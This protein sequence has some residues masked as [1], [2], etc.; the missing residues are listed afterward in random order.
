V[1]LE[2]RL[3]L[4]RYLHH[5]L[6]AEGLESLKQAL[7]EVEEGPS[8]GG[9]SHFFHA[10]A[11]RRGIRIPVE[12]LREYDTR[13]LG[14]E[15]RLGRARG[16]L[17]LRYFQYLALLY[18]EVLLD[19]LT[20]DS[21]ALAA[22]INAFLGSLQAQGRLA[23]FPAFETADLTRLAFFLA[24]GAGKTLLM[25]AHLW[26]VEHY[27][28]HG[29]RPNALVQR[30]DGRREFEGI[31][32]ITP[33]E[34][35]SRQHLEEFELSGIEASHLVHNPAGLPSLFGPRVQ[36]VE[37][38]KLSETA[39]G[40][41]LSVPL[42]SLGSAN[43]VL[44]DEG[45][46]GVGSEA[47]TWK[48]RQKQ[49]SAD[50]MLL[51]YSATFAQ[52]V[53]AASR[54]V[55]DELLEEYGK[56]IVFDYSYRH[57]YGENFGK[58][59]EVLNL[60]SID[61][62]R[63]QDLLLGGLLLFYQQVHVFR[64]HATALHPY[65]IAPPLWVFLGSKVNAVFTR[66]GR[67]RSDVATAVEFLRRFL[68]DRGWAVA[69]IERTMAGRSGL[70]DPARHEDVFQPRLA[71]LAGDAEE[72]YERICRDVFHGRGGLEVLEIKGADGELGLRASTAE[73]AD[74]P[75]F[76]VIN[77]GDVSGFKRL[78][79]EQAGIE[80]GEDHFTDSLFEEVN[81]PESPLTVLI[82]AKKF[83]EGWSS[84]RVST[85]G[86]LN[87]GRGEGSQ[88]IQLFGRGVRLRGRGGSLRRSAARP[89]PDP[90]APEVLRVLETL[91]ILGWNADYLA[92]FQSMLEQEELQPPVEVPV[93]TLFD[94]LRELP[95]PQPRSGYSAHGET[96]VLEA[97]RSIRV[98]V[99][100]T[101]RAAVLAGGA[102]RAVEAGE[103]REVSFAGRS[104]HL[105]LL[106]RD[107]L[108]TSA[109]E[110][111]AQRGYGNLYISR[112]AILPV[113]QQATV[114]VDRA[115]LARPE[116]V[117]EAAQRAV[118]LY[119][120]RFMARRE[121]A[122]ESLHLVPGKLRV[123]ERIPTGYTVRVGSEELL[124]QLRAL[125]AD[126]DRLRADGGIPLPRLHV[127]RHL[128]TPLLVKPADEY[129]ADLQLSPPG[130]EPSEEQFLRDLRTF[131]AEHLEDPEY[132]DAEL[133]ILRNMPGMGV[134]FYQRSGFFP[135]FI[136]WLATPGGPTRVRFV[137]PHGMHHGGLEGNADKAAAFEQ[138][139]RL[140]EEADFRG[141]NLDVGGY[142]VTQ[143]PL[144]DIPG[145]QAKTWDELAAEF[146]LLPQ[147]DRYIEKILR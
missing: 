125:V 128:W 54:R 80:V 39:T 123:R 63:A 133:Y 51:E 61:E 137:E 118:T 134:G 33:N 115:D 4:N 114:R 97:D 73:G 8:G 24:T 105:A 3:V 76:G 95:V 132:R 10:L 90:E 59:F 84:W 112:A 89:D 34:G 83:V 35:L 94:E 44:V 7:S 55:R 100:L 14:Y 30:L 92:A 140:N 75:Y 31:Y 111:K 96:W 11:G 29:K 62:D 17:R 40:D 106:D 93:F 28:R 5:L 86:L 74:R 146:S 99:D 109:L 56:S 124:A 43:L 36:V 136:V 27:L 1:R 110:Y 65:R 64:A 129:E 52:A 16:G 32:L 116:R 47:R 23:G 25:H 66:G 67:R 145:A 48:T 71:R 18:T 70:R 126:P 121:R 49:L 103:G 21:D 85:M 15:A 82:G 45:H 78:L 142:L 41:G 147:R 122:A 22:E 131:W 42:A 9:Q 12:D 130:L 91:N 101:S 6:G 88:V 102:R 113:L 135:D 104:P 143:T 107:A 120:D 141:A 53:G 20:R 98:L 50:G 19:R 119:L 81:E 138:L 72:L 127:D 13:I 37:I 68:E 77:I 26:Q 60:E 69:A 108:L 144:T 79:Q 87:M 38:S 2:Q 117:Q 58:D 57:F 46:K 139:R